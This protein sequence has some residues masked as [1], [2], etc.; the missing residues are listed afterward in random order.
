MSGR[1]IKA[2]SYRIARVIDSIPL[3]L[4]E[5]K[6]VVDLLFSLITSKKETRVLLLR[7]ADLT[8]EP[9]R[10]AFNDLKF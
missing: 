9:T 10:T 2:R 8:L 4:K 6:N 3:D 5:C 7:L 1:K